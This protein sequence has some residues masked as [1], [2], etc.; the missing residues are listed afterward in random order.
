MSGR[1][2]QGDWGDYPARARQPLGPE[3]AR[4]RRGHTQRQPGVRG[5][6]QVPVRP[7]GGG[8]SRFIAIV[9][10][11]VA[12]VIVVIGGIAA[13]SGSGLGTVPVSLLPFPQ[14]T[15]TTTGQ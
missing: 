7:N 5:P 8:R 6:G 1:S 15:S 2:Y 3:A 12:A 9:V 11:V 14:N 4:Q 13:A 10:L